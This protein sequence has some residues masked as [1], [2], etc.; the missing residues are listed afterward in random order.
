MRKCV[1]G[2]QKISIAKQ[3]SFLPLAAGNIDMSIDGTH[4][5]VST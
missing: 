2:S 3:K 4:D 5:T 1:D